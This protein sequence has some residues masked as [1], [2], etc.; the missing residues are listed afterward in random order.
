M[1]TSSQYELVE[2]GSHE[3]AE[4]IEKIAEPAQTSRTQAEKDKKSRA[5]ARIT[6][7]HLD[8]I[9]DDFWERRPWLLSGKPGKVPKMP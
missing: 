7:Q 8:M 6:V 2:P 3:V 1:L 9:K 5:K 4:D